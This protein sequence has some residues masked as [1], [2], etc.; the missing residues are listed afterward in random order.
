MLCAS[1]LGLLLILVTGGREETRGSLSFPVSMQI[2][3]IQ[4]PQ[5]KKKNF[6]GSH[7][8]ERVKFSKD[9]F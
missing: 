3:G 8:K 7:T 2:T 1:H 6:K 4:N 5:K 9:L